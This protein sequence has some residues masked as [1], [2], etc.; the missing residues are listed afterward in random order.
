M[1]H[2]EECRQRIEEA[3]GADGNSDRAKEVKERFDHYAAQ[4]VEEGDVRGKYPRE[5]DERKEHV[6]SESAEEKAMG[7]GA[8]KYDIGTPGKMDA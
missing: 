8:E 7:T 4:R 5:E 1:P 2:T 3:I 6:A